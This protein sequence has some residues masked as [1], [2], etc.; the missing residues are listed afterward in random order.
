MKIVKESAVIMT[1][2]QIEEAVAAMAGYCKSLNKKFTGVLGLAKGGLIPA[3][4]LAYKLNLPLLM[5]PVEDC[6]IVDDDCWSGVSLMQFNR[7]GMDKLP[8]TILL[9]AD[10]YTANTGKPSLA[11]FAYMTLPKVDVI[12][13]WTN[14]ESDWWLTSTEVPDMDYEEYEENRKPIIAVDFDNTL[15]IKGKPNKELFAAIK[16]RY[17]EIDFVL[18]TCRIGKDLIDA[19]KF[20][21]ANGW[22]PKYV[23]ENVEKNLPDCRKIF[24]DYY[25]DDLSV[26]Q[27]DLSFFDN[28][29]NNIGQL[30]K[31]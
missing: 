19:I 22:S 13:P 23:N 27:D 28:I 20:C 26:Y 25:I 8:Y 11:H 4:M 12:F 9:I 2:A 30:I 10:R 5:N 21:E 16:Q 31:Q 18:W 24:A 6:I 7:E 15:C 14:L 17:D 29:V 3:T 1:W